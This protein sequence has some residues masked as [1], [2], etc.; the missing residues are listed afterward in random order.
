MSKEKLESLN[1]EINEKISNLESLKAECE[2]EESIHG[3]PSSETVAKKQVVES[4]WKQSLSEYN[5][6][7]GSIKK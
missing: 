1:K 3:E 7:K 5:K 2:K 6:L 4:E